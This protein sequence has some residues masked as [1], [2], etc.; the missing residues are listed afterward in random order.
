MREKVNKMNR[1]KI[2]KMEW[3]VHRW[4]DFDYSE[5]CEIYLALKECDFSSEITE[6]LMKELVYQ[7]S[8][9]EMIIEG[10]TEIG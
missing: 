2:G 8:L 9:R 6:D 7:K 1:G 10:E 3:G 5:I 4:S